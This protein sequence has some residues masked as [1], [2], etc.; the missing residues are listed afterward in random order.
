MTKKTHVAVGVAVTL[1]I[2]TLNPIAS[3]GVLGAIAPD[4]DMMLGIKHR[5]TTHSLIALFISTI[6]IT[7]LNTK[8]GLVWGL[9]YSIHLFLDSFTKMGVPFLYPFKNNYYGLKLIRTGQSEDLFI[10]L[11]AIFFIGSTYLY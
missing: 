9:N 11:L 5:T 7:L 10:C 6:I 3:I 4:W 1:Q 8:I 2:I